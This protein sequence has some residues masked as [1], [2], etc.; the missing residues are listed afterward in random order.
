M[1]KGDR[2]AVAEK[3]NVNHSLLSV[4][5]GSVGPE[6]IQRKPDSE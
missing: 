1:G 5:E 6:M 2:I 4:C 3:G